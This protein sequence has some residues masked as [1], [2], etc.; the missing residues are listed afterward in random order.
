MKER[1]NL[2]NFILKKAIRKST[3]N[4]GNSNEG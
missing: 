1:S 2:R 3:K 4:M